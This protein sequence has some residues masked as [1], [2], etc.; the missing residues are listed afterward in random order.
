MWLMHPILYSTL[1]SSEFVSSSELQEGCII[2]IFEVDFHNS[3]YGYFSLV[4]LKNSQSK[5]PDSSIS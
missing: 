1:D 5:L 3:S 2:E 4:E